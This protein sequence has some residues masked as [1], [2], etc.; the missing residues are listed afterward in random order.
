MMFKLLGT[1]GL[2]HNLTESQIENIAQKTDGF[3]GADM[4]N[5]CQ[6]AALYPITSMSFSAVVKIDTNSVRP[7]TYHDF[8]EAL[9]NVR[10]S[11]SPDDLQH[12]IDWNKKYGSGNT[13]K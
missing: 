3:S 13:F 10:A 9:N 12:Y 5:L 11:V 6:E 4:K 1:K 7:V 2:K 8:C